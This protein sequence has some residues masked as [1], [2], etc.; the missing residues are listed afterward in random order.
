MPGISTTTRACASRQSAWTASTDI[1]DFR[2]KKETALTMA[3]TPPCAPVLRVVGDEPPVDGADA[4]SHS[5]LYT[6]AGGRGARPFLGRGPRGHRAGRRRLR[7]ELRR[8]APR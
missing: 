2:L 4:L 7:Q 8:G 5:L 3:S 6:A 1:P